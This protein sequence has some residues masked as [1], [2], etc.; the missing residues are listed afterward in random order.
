MEDQKSTLGVVLE[1]VSGLFRWI[2]E[3]EG[4]DAL[5]TQGLCFLGWSVVWGWRWKRG[6]S[7]GGLD[8]R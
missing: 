3:A 2:D 5:A 8:W 7:F 6:I 1:E 4:E